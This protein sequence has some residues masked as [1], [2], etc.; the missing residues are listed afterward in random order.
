M[1]AS[2]KQLGIIKD[3]CVSR[4]SQARYDLYFT[5]KRIG[6]VYLGTKGGTYYG[7]GGLVG[8]LIA[9]GVNVT[10]KKIAENQLKKK[11]EKM[12][13]LTLDKLLPLNKKSCFY[14]YDEVEEI[15]LVSGKKLNFMILSEECES[16]FSPTKE[17][18]EEL[19]NL[20]PTIEVLK[21]KLTLIVN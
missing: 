6:I 4:D 21:K 9:E 13:N 5:D 7:T 16:E 18:F 1:S 3:I 12:T 20:L 8:A 15:K 14:T 10:A 11:E 17:Q 19:S 2:E